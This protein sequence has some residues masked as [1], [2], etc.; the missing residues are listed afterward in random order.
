[1]ISKIEQLPTK[2]KLEL[3]I[4]DFFLVCSPLE[5][6]LEDETRKR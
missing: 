1:M 2:L 4:I 6:V 3:Q 5:R